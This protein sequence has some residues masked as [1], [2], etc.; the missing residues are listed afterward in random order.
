MNHT[1]F[2]FN[3][4]I[5]WFSKT[6]SDSFTAKAF[7]QNPTLFQKKNTELLSSKTNT[8]TSQI[9]IYTLNINQLS[10]NNIKNKHTKML[11]LLHGHSIYMA[12]IQETRLAITS[13]LS[14][15][16]DYTKWRKVRQHGEGRG[17]I[18][19]V[20]QNVLSHWHQSTQNKSQATTFWKSPLQK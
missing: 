5:Q 9:S 3:I 7:T 13:T 2:F 12:L 10:I 20:H 4:L 14:P 19:S 1:T 17:L 16:S 11:N 6:E 8:A 15:F 18:I